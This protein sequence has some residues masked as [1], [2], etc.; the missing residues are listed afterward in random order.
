MIERLMKR[1]E[2]PVAGW[3]VMAEDWQPEHPEGVRYW[4]RRLQVLLRRSS[5]DDA[6]KES[7]DPTRRVQ[8][9]DPVLPFSG[10]LKSETTARDGDE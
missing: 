3:I 5:G 2:K 6:A 7:G 1:H 4:L 10:H 9:S 8:I